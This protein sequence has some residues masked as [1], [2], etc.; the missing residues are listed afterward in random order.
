MNQ[1]H[2]HAALRQAVAYRLSSCL[3]LHLFL[4]ADILCQDHLVDSM[5]PERA[6]ALSPPSFEAISP[7]APQLFQA[8]VTESDSMEECSRVFEGSYIRLRFQTSIATA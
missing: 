7:R 4:S 8:G 2:S 1:R 6:P 5:H 3:P